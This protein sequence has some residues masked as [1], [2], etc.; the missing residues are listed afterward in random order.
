M[1]KIKKKNN[2]KLTLLATD[3]NINIL[4]NHLFT[5]N[6]ENFNAIKSEYLKMNNE[7]K[8]LFDNEERIKK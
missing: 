8:D 6:E 7:L 3:D 1:K 5:T 4:K 2:E